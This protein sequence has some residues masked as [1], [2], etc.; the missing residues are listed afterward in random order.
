MSPEDTGDL[1]KRLPDLN[2]NLKDARD[3]KKAQMD[4]LRKLT[5]QRDSVRADM[6]QFF[7]QRSKLRDEIKRKINAKR[8]LIEDKR[9]KERA[10]AAEMKAA[11]NERQRADR[12]KNEAAFMADKIK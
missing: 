4:Q 1:Q 8:E 9:A 12:L 11:K 2:Q 5:E 3:A 6:S 10:F 7:D